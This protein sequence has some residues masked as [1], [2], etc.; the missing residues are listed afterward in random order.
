MK[1]NSITLIRHGETE[2]SRT[3][4]HT[5]LSDIPLTK[6]GINEARAI[7]H[8]LN[9]VSFNHIWTSPSKRARDTAQLAGFKAEISHYL[10]EWDYGDYEGKTSQ[11]I[12]KANPG[13]TIF[14]QNPP[15]GETAEEVG[16]RADHFWKMVLALEGDV[17]FVSSGHISRV[18]L[19]RFL[20]FPVDYGR[21]FSLST[22]SLSLLTFEHNQP[23]VKLWND[24][25][26]YQRG[27]FIK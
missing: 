18:L 24:V 17:A 6:Q 15:N 8:R 16:K 14:S 7:G 23:V 11:E 21:Y 20:G 13:W 19:A 4:Q 5:G 2:W 1:I 22:A 26:H 12:W 9:G 10:K 3:G 27:W 25:S